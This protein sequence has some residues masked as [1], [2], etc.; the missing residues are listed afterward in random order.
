MVAYNTFKKAFVLNELQ[1]SED[2]N[3][4]IDQTVVMISVSE[5]LLFNTGSYRVKSGAYGLIEKLAAVINS[6]PS[7]DIKSIKKLLL[8][9]AFLCF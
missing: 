4:D 1:N 9:G 2:L 3:I 5:K 6:E 7:M 8:K